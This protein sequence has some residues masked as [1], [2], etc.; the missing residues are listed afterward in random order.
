MLVV[1]QIVIAVYAFMYTE[2]LAVALRKGFWTVWEDTSNPGSVEAVH[3][4]QR[5]LNCCGNEGPNDWLTRPGGIP[6]SCCAGDSGTC[7]INNAFPK[8]C[9]PLLHDLVNGSGMLIA[10]IAIVFAAFEVRI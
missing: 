5:N 4:L 7:N 10:W 8:G 9:G 1:A 6:Q 2:D 3:G